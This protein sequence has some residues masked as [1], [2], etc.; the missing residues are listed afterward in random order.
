MKHLK[1]LSW[2]LIVV[3]ALF[4]VG[5]SDDDDDGNGTGPTAPTDYLSDIATLGDAYFASTKNI[6]AANLWDDIQN[7]VSLFMIDFRSAAAFDTCGHIEDA[8]NWSI[9]DLM[10]NLSLIPSGAKVVCVCYTGQTASQATSVLN[11]LGYNAYNLKWGMCGWTADETVNLAK[12][13]SVTP[14]GQT[15]EITAN[16]F[17]GTFELPEVTP[18]ASSA[19]GAIE[20]LADA[21][22]N[23]GTKNITAADLYT[24]IND[25]D[26]LND[27]YVV[28][29]FPEANYNAGHIPGA[30][31]LDTGSF[32]VEELAYLPTDQQVVIYCYTGQ[33]SSQVTS[34]LNVLGY[35][36]YSLKFGLNAITNDPAV[37][38]TSVY[39]PPATSY[40]VVTGP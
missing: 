30:Y 39:T 17:A 10:D 13:S 31:W 22:F 4:M 3:F 33:T 6:T 35:N 9:G 20:I 25:G 7:A 2:L 24:L 11:M 8:V 12:W 34:Y 28:N 40:P 32:G 18:E 15:L 29:Y 14:G 5:C 38:G 37:V 16:A 26:P 23:V 21:Y 1:H 36:A 27:P 19:T